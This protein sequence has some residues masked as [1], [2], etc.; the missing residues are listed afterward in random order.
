MTAQDD[1]TARSVLVTGGAGYLGALAVDALADHGVER[2]VTI[3]VRDP[4]RPRPGTTHVTADVRTADLPGL[5][6][7][8][9]VDAVVHLAA[10]VNPPPGMSE[11]TL[12]DI[13]VGGTER[14]LEACVAAGVGHV[15]VSSSGAAYGYH[16][17]NRGRF[18][19]EDDPVRGSA[20]FAY[21]K[22]KAEVE[23]LLAGYRRRHPDLGQLVLRA[24]TILGEGTSN[25]ITDLFEKRAVLGLRGVDVPF[26]FVWDHDVA[27]VI[28]R[29]VTGGITGVFN[30]AGDGVLTLADI[31]RIEDKRL[32]ALPPGLLARAL[33]LLRAA[34]LTQYGPEQ[35]DFLRYRPVLANDALKRA[36]PGLPRRSSAEAYEI[37]RTGR[38]ARRG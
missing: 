11:Q 25:L 22:H 8:H 12:H 26:V 33:G 30:L 32:V 4:D 28:A 24:G 9:A 35:V 15:T 3:D 29:G 23:R 1:D 19:T 10:I 18:L 31:A 16:L 20:H 34:R 13:E 14:V 7:D 36:F 2:I 5:M 38:E 37:Y 6:A 27:E 21:S 17:A